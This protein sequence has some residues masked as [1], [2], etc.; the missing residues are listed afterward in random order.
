MKDCLSYEIKF[1]SFKLNYEKVED[2]INRLEESGEEINYKIKQEII[3]RDSLI[4]ISIYPDTPI[5]HYDIIHYDLGL[6][7]NKMMYIISN[8]PN[9]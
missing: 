1:N 4:E 8:Q 3:D 6:A 7:V 5:G 2:Y 9:N